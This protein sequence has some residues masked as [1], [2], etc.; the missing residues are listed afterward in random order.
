MTG[1]D[2]DRLPRRLRWAAEQLG[3][4][5]DA[6]PEE[7][8]A[9]W[10]RLLPEEDFVPLSEW[11][12]SLVALLR[13]ESERGLEARADEAAAREE[14]DSLRDEVEDFAEGF[15]GLPA[16][17]RRQRWQELTARCAFA[18]A[19]RARLRQLGPGLDVQSFPRE[20]EE[21][22]RVVELAGHLRDLFVLRPQPRACDRQALLRRMEEE[23]EQWREAGGRLR[24]A[25]PALA[26]LGSDLL[27]ELAIL[28]P[29]R[30][31]PPKSPP[32]QPP[33]QPPSASQPAPR[34]IIW[35]I[36][37]IAIAGSRLFIGMGNKSSSPPPPVANPRFLDQP[38]P[39]RE[40]WGEALKRL[41]GDEANGDDKLKKVVEE[42]PPE[43][44]AKVIKGQKDKPGGRSP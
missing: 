20:G 9:A 38:M 7:V 17:A 16:E 42:L 35:V 4:E 11:R 30:L 32:F 8:R 14:E 28:S 41:V 34:W 5:A 26:S 13:R 25:Y 44:K 43:Q 18:P 40:E 23:R 3:L 10:L 12:W 19:L 22:T 36:I 15:W 33:S 29:A 6:S 27:D 21:D 31:Y 2:P 39:P 37:G 24:R 1:I